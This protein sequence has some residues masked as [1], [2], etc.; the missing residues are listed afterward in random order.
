MTFA[1]VVL[2]AGRGER[3]GQD[4]AL[5]DLGG[6]LAVE[7]VVAA[8][9]A[10][11]A[12]EV[13]VVRRAAAAPLPELAVRVL[14]VATAERL[15]KPLLVL[16]LDLQPRPDLVRDWIALHRIVTLN[17]A[18]PRE[19]TSPGVGLLATEFMRQVLCK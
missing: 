12:D 7:R 2:A 13:V 8:C 9:R 16:D 1:A 17:V 4:K 10:A 19:S 15:G 3:L 18:G 11:G 5:V 6:Q 14:T